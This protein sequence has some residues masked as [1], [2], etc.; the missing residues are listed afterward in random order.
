MMGTFYY[1]F[2]ER[3]RSCQGRDNHSNKN[4]NGHHHIRH[5]ADDKRDVEGWS[6]ELP[7][8]NPEDAVSKLHDLARNREGGLQRSGW[9]G[10]NSCGRECN[11]YNDKCL[12]MWAT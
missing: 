9:F 3:G 8:C 6:M 7:G 11:L 12:S 5:R 1:P 2:K 4:N 10:E